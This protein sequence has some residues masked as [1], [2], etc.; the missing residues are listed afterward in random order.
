MSRNTSRLP[1]AIVGWLVVLLSPTFTG[2]SARLLAQESKWETQP[3]GVEDNLRNVT[4]LNNKKGFAVGD[5]QTLL[6][7]TDGGQSWRRMIPKKTS[8]SFLQ[9]FFSSPTEGW[10]FSDRVRVILRTTDGGDTW[11]AVPLPKEDIALKH[12]CHASVVGSTLYYLYWG[13]SGTHLY[14]T[15]DAGQTW[16]ELN[17]KITVGGVSDVASMV[18]V[19]QQH[20]WYTRFTGTPGTAY[21]GITED[22]GRTWREQRLE[23]KWKMKLIFI[24]K[25]HGWILPEFGKIH[26]TSDGGKT[27]APQEIGHRA[28]QPL[29]DM[30][31]LDTQSG[32][33]VHSANE[34]NISRYQVRQTAD[35]GKTWTPMGG[36]VFTTEI[37]KGVA[38]SREGEGWVVGTKGFISHY[39]D[40]AK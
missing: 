30:Q 26:T 24:D 38:F 27:W 17:N 25:Q 6:Q 1:F 9:I 8:D 7:T 22:G 33:V 20:G 2:Q 12:V 3:S 32:Y 19:D 15:H 40:Q 28:T 10:V 16:R 23:T 35:G 39:R 34:R 14:E 31:F 36:Y 29:L 5:N 13:L 11:N 4:F 21:A 18:F 37:L